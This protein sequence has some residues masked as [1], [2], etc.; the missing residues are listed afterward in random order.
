LNICCR[1]LAIKVAKD[2]VKQ[3][4]GIFNNFLK[5]K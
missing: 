3:V 1:F 5:N 2:A 4:V